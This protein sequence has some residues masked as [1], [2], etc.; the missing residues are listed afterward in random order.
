M[1]PL[2][3]NVVHTVIVKKE[4]VGAIQQITVS[5]ALVYDTV[6]EVKARF[7][8]LF[9]ADHDYVINLST[10][11][12]VDSTGFAL[13]SRFVNAVTEWGQHITIVARKPEIAELCRIAQF[14]KFAPVMT[15]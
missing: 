8:E 3:D 9:V 10:A 5:G 4:Q 14:E 1:G 7:D 13:M 11:D 2:G 6:Q 12:Y 15:H